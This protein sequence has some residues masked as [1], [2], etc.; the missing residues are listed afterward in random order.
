MSTRYLY[1]LL[2]CTSPCGTV[3]AQTAGSSSFAGSIRG[4]AINLYIPF[5]FRLT[6]CESFCVAHIVMLVFVLLLTFYSWSFIVLSQ[7]APAILCSMQTVGAQL[8][9]R[10]SHPRAF[11]VQLCAAAPSISALLRCK[12]PIPA[13]YKQREPGGYNVT[14]CTGQPVTASEPAG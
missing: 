3:H 9:C 14:G 4:S 11:I 8:F 1:K 12:L 2:F 10:V 5:D 13:E 7:G 6:S